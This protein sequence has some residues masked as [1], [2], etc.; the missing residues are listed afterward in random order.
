MNSGEAQQTFAL[1]SLAGPGSSGALP[2]SDLQA[3][4]DKHAP[5]QRA[6]T[7]PSDPLQLCTP[8]S[9]RQ[10]QSQG[11]GGLP[12][13][14]GMKTGEPAGT[15]PAELGS[16]GRTSSPPT[17]AKLET[18]IGTKLAQLP[19]H[20]VPGMCP[21][22]GSGAVCPLKVCS[23]GHQGLGVCFAG[24]NLPGLPIMLPWSPS[25]TAPPRLSLINP[26]TP[27]WQLPAIMYS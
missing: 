26:W 15:T 9:L 5:L 10:T 19:S 16:P 11:L 17:P 6:F 2:G 14:G 1:S 27:A 21:L 22:K 24:C 13:D 3:R 20:E 23:V 7:A 25:R 4:T 12:N 8:A 18:S